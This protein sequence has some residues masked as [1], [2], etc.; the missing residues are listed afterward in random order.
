MDKKNIVKKTM[1]VAATTLISRFL[2]LA[3]EILFGRFIGVGIIADAFNTAFI[4]PNSLRKVF[5]EGALTS[6]LVPTYIIMT[7]KETQ[8]QADGLIALFF[9]FFESTLLILCIAVIVKASSTISLIMPGFSQEQIAATVPLLKILMPFIFFISVSA[10]LSGPLNAIHHFFVPAV[11]PVILNIIFIASLILS[12]VCSWPID[13]F[14]YG[15]LLGGLIQCVM[16]VWTYVYLGFGFAVPDKVSWCYFIQALSKFVMGF[17]SA[18]VMEI[19]LFI[20]Q[21][22]ASYLPIGSVTIIKYA[23][24]FMAIPL[25][26]FGVA[27]STILLPHF[28]KTKLETP[29]KM[30]FYIFESLKLVLWVTIPATLMLM[31]L[32]Q[33]IFIT[34]FVSAT[35]KF[36]ADRVPEAAN[37]LIAFLI[38]LCFFSLNKLLFSVYFAMH[39][40]FWPTCI[41]IIGTMANIGAN[42]MLVSYG[43]AGIAYATTL[44]GVIQS[45]L[46][47]YFLHR[48]HKLSISFFEI[49]RFCIFYATQ[50]AILLCGT[51]LLF[52]AIIYVLSHYTDGSFF[53]SSFGFWLWVSPLM[54]FFYFSLYCSR[55]WF[56][57]ELYFLD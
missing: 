12:H 13:Y 33:D 48:H 56:K 5:A 9:I 40:M 4:L 50:V 41:S 21:G 23:S 37:I 35:S 6:A 27:F 38:G 46:C 53:I 44:S 8:K 16:H 3:R 36:P 10:L 22:F 31:F 42:W 1:Q 39:D 20:D 17:F 54:C 32:S 11:G 26:V 19:G 29:E 45:L 30:H 28:T 43:G 2:G 52:R 57:I 49:A 24:R 15:V 7:K 47:F 34:F 51:W 18:S 55:K 14:C 25:G